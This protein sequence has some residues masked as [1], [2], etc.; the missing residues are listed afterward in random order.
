[1][2]RVMILG[3]A[4]VLLLALLLSGCTLHGDWELSLQGTAT[5]TGSIGYVIDGQEFIVDVDQGDTAQ[6]IGPKLVALM[7][8]SGL[9]VDSETAV[10]PPHYQDQPYYAFIVRGVRQPSG[11]PEVLGISVGYSGPLQPGL[12]DV[13]LP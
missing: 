1:M 13:K 4:A 5:S 8:A 9:M 6:D 12:E 10:N 3:A 2:T 7:R 11:K